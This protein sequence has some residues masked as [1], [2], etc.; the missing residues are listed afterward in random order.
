MIHHPLMSLIIFLFSPIHHYSFLNFRCFRLDCACL[1]AHS[2]LSA[3]RPRADRM[4]F[5]FRSH[6]PSLPKLQNLQIL[7]LLLSWPSESFPCSYFEYIESQSEKPRQSTFNEMY[8]Q[9]LSWEEDWLSPFFAQYL[10]NIEWIEV[11]FL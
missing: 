9:Y 2:G 1:N 6:L 8:K 4:F 3:F 11:Y 10:K 7:P 5:V